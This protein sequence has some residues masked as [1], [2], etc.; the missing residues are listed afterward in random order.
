MQLLLVVVV[1]GGGLPFSGVR[2]DLQGWWV[3]GGCGVLVVGPS[4]FI[5]YLGKVPYHAYLIHLS[6]IRNN[7]R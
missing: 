3:G 5:L 2:D 1:E 6:Y 7:R 4:T